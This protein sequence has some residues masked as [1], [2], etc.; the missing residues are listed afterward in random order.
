MFFSIHV[1]KLLSER[2]MAHET[3]TILQEE[4]YY[5][6]SV[7]KMES[8]FQSGGSIPVKGTLL[9]H[10]GNM[11]YQAEAP[12]GYVQRVNF[13]LTMN[14]GETLNGIGFFDTRSRKL[15]KWVEMN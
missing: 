13:T 11:A 12:A 5:L 1:E 2:K 3:A 9:Y 14:S 6:T 4:Y 15:I 8:L 10:R 7:K